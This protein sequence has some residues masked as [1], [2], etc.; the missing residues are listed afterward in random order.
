MDHEVLDF[1]RIIPNIERM[2][3]RQGYHEKG[4][5]TEIMKEP[6]KELE[7]VLLQMKETLND[8]QHINLS[9]IFKEK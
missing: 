7:K 8:H 3:M 4:Q 1:P 2:N 5:A 9:E 6:Q